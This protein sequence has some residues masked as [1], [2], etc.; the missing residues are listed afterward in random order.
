[1][2]TTLGFIP[3]LSQKREAGQGLVEY[4]LILSLVAIGVIGITA[5]LGENVISIYCRIVLTL[6]PDT[7]TTVC[8]QL[9]LDCAASYGGGQITGS[10]S[11]V[12]LPNDSSINQV[13]FSIDGVIVWTDYEPEYCIDGSNL[14]C[15]P[16]TMAL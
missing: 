4:A 10:A 13:D 9:E 11:A 2:K 3:H 7:E 5:L 16:R 8:G 1:M 6:Q 12:S 15:L 14:E